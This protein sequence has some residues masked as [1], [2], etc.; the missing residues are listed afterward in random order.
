[1]GGWGVA[2]PLGGEIMHFSN[3]QTL[4]RKRTKRHHES[5]FLCGD[6][7]DRVSI[8]LSRGMDGSNGIR[9]KM[10]YVE[11]YFKK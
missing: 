9:E 2:N 10:L 1:L 5:I 11:Y 4:Q 8:S 7:G 3:K 6:F